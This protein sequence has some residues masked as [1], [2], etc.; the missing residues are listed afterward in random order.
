M[1]INSNIQF[2]YDT[3]RSCLSLANPYAPQEEVQP[4]I[5]F[6]NRFFKIDAKDYRLKR[7]QTQEYQSRYA[8]YV[9]V[10]TLEGMR[11]IARYYNEKYFSSEGKADRKICVTQGLEEMNK[12]LEGFF[13]N[14]ALHIIGLT[15]PRC[16]SPGAEESHPVAIIAEKQEGGQVRLYL[17]D[18]VPSSCSFEKAFIRLES[19][20]SKLKED[21]IIIYNIQHA[22]QASVGHCKSEALLFLKNALQLDTIFE[23]V[24]CFT[25]K[26]FKLF[27]RK[28][29]ED[30]NLKKITR[31]TSRK[32]DDVEYETKRQ[33]F[34]CQPPLLKTLQKSSYLSLFEG[35]DRDFLDTKP[36]KTKLETTKNTV[37][38]KDFFARNRV[39]SRY[40][41]FHY[42]RGEE[43]SIFTIQPDHYQ[44]LEENGYLAHKSM[45]HYV[46]L[47]QKLEGETVPQGLKMG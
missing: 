42:T 43:K 36:V 13:N 17:A 46:F 20:H 41:W 15:C 4:I 32:P 3:H 19:I 16:I 11:E 14:P 26:D 22:R 23:H 25:K 31:I 39:Y 6:K 21:Q 37:E 9:P 45:E 47:N 2:I 35:K 38:Y 30:S 18:G 28:Y 27:K 12:Q 10:L 24:L 44:D 34:I 8:R 1:K 40:Y 29:D 5:N 33:F 7:G